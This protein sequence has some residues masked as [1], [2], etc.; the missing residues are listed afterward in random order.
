MGIVSF[1]DNGS[2]L[3]L[4]P[5]ANLRSMNKLIPEDIQKRQ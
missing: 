5:A 1:D 4:L 3:V 2:E